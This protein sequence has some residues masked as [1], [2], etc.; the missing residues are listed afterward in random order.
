MRAHSVLGWFSFSLLFAVACTKSPG[1]DE[2]GQ[3]DTDTDT[4]SSTT[5][6][7]IE[8]ADPAKPGPRAFSSASVQIPV[9]NG[10]LPSQVYVPDGASG[11]PVVVLLHGFMLGPANYASYAEQLASWGYVVIL[12]QLPGSAFN[13]VPH[14]ALR[15]R[16]IEL[17]DWVDASATD[18]AHPLAG[19]LDI[20]AVGLAGHSMGGKVSALVAAADARPIA[21]FLIDPVDS[22]PPGSSDPEG[23]PSVTPELMPNITIPVV[24]LGETVNSTGGIGPSCAP[25][26]DNFQQFFSNAAGPALQIDVLGASHM[27][28]LDD[29][30]C[31]FLCLACPSGTAPP[32]RTRG[33]T[34]QYLVA[35]FERALKQRPAYNAWLTGAEMDAN[36]AAGWV[37][38][39]QANGF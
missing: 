12:P 31:G 38:V 20:A 7:A 23:Y 37:S 36:V 6:T 3:P 33:L 15:D 34:A 35:F 10:T 32:A 22:A 5:D 21:A 30:N 18:S 27:E 11:A 14:A 39:D 13:P 16:V 28:F 24:Y 17:L 26:A 1:G 9:S 25:A 2:T 19:M 8:L 29:P 4:A